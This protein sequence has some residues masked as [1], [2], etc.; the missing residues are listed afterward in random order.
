MGGGQKNV[1][2]P[3]P[4]ALSTL[5]VRGRERVAGVAAKRTFT[6]PGPWP[7]STLSVR[8]RERVAAAAAKRTF[9]IPGPWPLVIVVTPGDRISCHLPEKVGDAISSHTLHTC[10][11]VPQADIHMPYRNRM[12]CAVAIPGVRPVLGTFD[13]HRLRRVGPAARPCW[14]RGSFERAASAT[15]SYARANQNIAP[16]VA[17]HA[18]HER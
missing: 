1:H 5:S 4:L 3:W 15:M 18:A 6:S 16:A 11:H 7:L 9:T 8:G 12:V 10:T 17:K 13:P 14:Q 2:H